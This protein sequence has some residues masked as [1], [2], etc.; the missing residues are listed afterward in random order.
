MGFIIVLI[1]IGIVIGRTV[2][3]KKKLTIQNN[4]EVIDEKREQE[5]YLELKELLQIPTVSGSNH[6]HEYLQTL[7]TM[8]PIYF[9]KAEKIEINSAFLFRIKGTKNNDLPS[10]ILAHVDVVEENGEW[11]YPAMDATLVDHII[12]GRGTIDNKGM[13]YSFFKAIE[14]LLKEGKEFEN[15]LYFMASHDEESLGLGVKHVAE[16]LKENKL[17]FKVIFDEGGAVTGEVMPGIQNDIALLGLCEKGYLDIEF[18]AKSKGGHSGSPQVDNPFSRLAKFMVE[19]EKPGYFKVSFMKT[20]KQMFTTIS[21]Y[22]TFP[23]RMLLGNMWLFSPLVKKVLPSFS[24]SIGAMMK[25]T[26]VFTRAQ[27]SDANNVIPETAKVTANIRNLPT[28]D[29]SFVINKLIK[30]AKKYDL[31]Y[32]ILYEK[33]ASS[34]TDKNHTEVTRVKKVIEQTMPGTIVCPYVTIG[35]TDCCHLDAFSD[36]VI[37]FSPIRASGQQIAA[38]HGINENIGV[39]ELNKA[40]EFF[41]CYLN[42]M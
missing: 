9:S 34:M 17:Q 8:F 40:I 27:G 24:P 16:Y 13:G 3:I 33:P 10:L 4:Y 12:Y 1:I 28:E 11:D 30:T 23:L 18:R 36:A 37:R 15:D 35:A 2:M 39:S 14:Q 5:L 32:S 19:V 22:M 42:S 31:E 26:I 20:V 29:M 21:P 7:E 25:T 41:Y 38:M 6:F